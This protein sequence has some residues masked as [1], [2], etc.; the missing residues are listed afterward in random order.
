MVVFVSVS[1][2][3]FS[4]RFVPSAPEHLCHRSMR[5]QVVDRFHFRSQP[6]ANRMSRCAIEVGW[7]VDSWVFEQA[8]SKVA[9]RFHRYCLLSC[10]MWNHRSAVVHYSHTAGIAHLR[11]AVSAQRCSCSRLTAS[12]DGM[13]EETCQVLG[14]FERVLAAP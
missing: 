12:A 8:G 7:Q 5:C 10:C 1:P 11:V 6:T 4:S 13:R 14:V 3:R 2:V 9:S